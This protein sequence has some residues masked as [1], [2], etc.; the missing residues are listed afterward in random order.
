MG[1]GVRIV[2]SRVYTAGFTRDG[3][4]TESLDEVAVWY[5]VIGVA[6]LNSDREIIAYTDRIRS[7]SVGAFGE[8]DLAGLWGPVELESDDGD[9]ARLLGGVLEIAV[10]I[11]THDGQ[12]FVLMDGTEVPDPMKSRDME[13]SDG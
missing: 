9:S 11:K 6:F 5:G 10:L 1:D 12:R 2:G 8:G 7:I 4:H 3:C 13:M